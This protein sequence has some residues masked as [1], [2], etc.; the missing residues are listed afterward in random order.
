[1]GDP[2][3]LGER[4]R[5]LWD[6][7][8]RRAADGDVLLARARERHSEERYTAALRGLYERVTST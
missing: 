6:D 5:A 2:D 7:P 1:M 4:L 8:A 3:A